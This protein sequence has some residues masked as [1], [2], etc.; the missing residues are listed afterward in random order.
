MTALYP[1]PLY[2]SNTNLNML[3]E[4]LLHSESPQGSVSKTTTKRVMLLGL[5]ERLFKHVELITML[6]T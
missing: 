3:P 2:F 6:P 5:T 1:S 4:F